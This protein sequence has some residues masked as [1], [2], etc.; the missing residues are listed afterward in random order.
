MK[1]FFIMKDTKNVIY[2]RHPYFRPHCQTV[3]F[4]FFAKVK[5]EKKKKKKLIMLLYSNSPAYT[6]I[7]IDKNTY[8]L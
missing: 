1:W 3:F 8:F 2:I 7:T 6:I 4:F 5:S